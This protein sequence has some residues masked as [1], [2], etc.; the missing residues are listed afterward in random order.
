M[1]EDK[2]LITGKH[3][4]RDIFCRECQHYLGWKYVSAR[5]YLGDFRA[6]LTTSTRDVTAHLAGLCVSGG[7]KVQGGAIH[8]RTRIGHGALRGQASSRQDDNRADG[9][10]AKARRRNV[11]ID[12][13]LD[14]LACIFLNSDLSPF[15]ATP[16]VL[17]H[18]SELP[19]FIPSV[20]SSQSSISHFFQ[21]TCR[22]FDLVLPIPVNNHLFVRP[23]L[24]S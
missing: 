20:C 3:T 19:P 15:P 14:S 11:L 13:L 18:L 23:R 24:L 10:S 5:P 17:I 2:N 7:R 12:F 9:Y 8:S 4:V 16:T 22:P 6:A 21:T 1:A